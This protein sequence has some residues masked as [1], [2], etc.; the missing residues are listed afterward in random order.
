MRIKCRMI[1][2]GFAEGEA[3]V[4]PEPISFFGGID[5]KTSVVIDKKHPLK[6]V[7]IKDKILIFPTGKGST[8]GSYVIYQLKLNKVAP[9]GIICKEADPV[10]AVGAIIAGIPMVDKPE[11]FDFKTGQYVR[12]NADEEYIEVVEKSKS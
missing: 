2:K 11:K 8:V 7:C 10:V 3:L 12:I 6:G 9:K 4:S 1:S 5:P